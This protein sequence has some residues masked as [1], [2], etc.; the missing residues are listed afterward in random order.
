VKDK[1]NAVE[2]RISSTAAQ[3]LAVQEAPATWKQNNAEEMQRERCSP[4]PFSAKVD[5]QT[6][7]HSFR[8]LKGELVKLIQ[9]KKQLLIRGVAVHEVSE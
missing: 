5:E 8:T 9:L 4:P 6:F 2:R 7:K 3:L 1:L